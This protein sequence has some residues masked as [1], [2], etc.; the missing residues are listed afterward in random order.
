MQSIVVQEGS[1]ETPPTRIVQES[2]PRFSENA[3]ERSVEYCECVVD[4][5]A[6]LF[7]VSSRDLRRPGRS[8]TATSRVRQIGMYVAHV[9]LRLNMTEVGRGFGRDRTTV[10]HACHLVED[11]RDNEEF[12]RLVVMTERVVAAAFRGRLED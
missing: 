3:E 11:L 6:A 7:G 8:N 9:V 4:I 2:A 1:R 10:Q 5:V 12:D